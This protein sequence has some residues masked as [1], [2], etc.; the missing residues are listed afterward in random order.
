MHT[1]RPN[2]SRARRPITGT[3]N[4]PLVLLVLVLVAVGA[5]FFVARERG[6][7]VFGGRIARGDSG[8]PVAGAAVSFALE[9]RTYSATSDSAGSFLVS[10]A[11]QPKGLVVM[12]TLTKEGF[13]VGQKQ[14]VVDA[15]APDLGQF[16]LDPL[17]PPAPRST[18]V[19]VVGGDVDCG[20]D[21]AVGDTVEISAQGTVD[22]GGAVLGL[23]APKLDANGDDQ[24]T[25]S[26]YPAPG[27]RKNSLIWRIGDSPWLQGR[28]SVS[29]VSD[30]AGRITL[31]ANDK[32]VSDNSR[33][34]SV[35][36]TV[37]KP[38]P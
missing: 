28:T 10:V 16:S 15:G 13:K 34:W 17:P 1:F 5:Y 12:L 8:A 11:G 2:L 33:G 29:R 18:T 6:P 27:L 37:R 14:V 24:P 21:A 31:R 20:L 25:A 36:V 30:R 4:M 32:D 9:G 35:T 26:D 23:G 3:A 7:T 22:F 38:G 19:T